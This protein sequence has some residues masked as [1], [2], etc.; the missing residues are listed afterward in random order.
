MFIIAP[1]VS[2][3]IGTGGKL[4]EQ[5]LIEA[6]QLDIQEMERVDAETQQEERP[7]LFSL[8][9]DLI[10][11]LLHLSEEMD[12]YENLISYFEQVLLKF[13]EWEEVGKVVGILNNLNDVLETME[14]REKQ[15][16]AIRRIL[17]IPSGVE[18]VNQLGFRLKMEKGDPESTLQMLQLLTRQALQPLVLLYQ[19]LRP[20]KWKP[21]V[22]DQ[23]LKLSRDDIEPLVKLLPDSKLPGILQILDLLGQVKH[24]WTLINTTSTSPDTF[25]S[26]SVP[27][28]FRMSYPP[29]IF[30]SLLPDAASEA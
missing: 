6:C 25:C 14:L 10:E 21:S 19:Q 15:V 29:T 5:S 3:A 7:D 1:S 4:P 16:F 28:Y 12:A 26:S 9:D 22:R 8:V 20:G 13:F 23:I 24:P 11:I 2:R 30:P 27:I 17:E 18:F